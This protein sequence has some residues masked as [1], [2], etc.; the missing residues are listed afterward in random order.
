MASTASSARESA[1]CDCP[2]ISEARSIF[3]KQAEFQCAVDERGRADRDSA[4][5][6]EEKRIEPDHTPDEALQQLFRGF[7]EVR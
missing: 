5:L 1:S 6:R 3:T 4:Y 2:R 7:V